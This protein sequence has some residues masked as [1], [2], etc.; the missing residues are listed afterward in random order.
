MA[1]KHIPKI[2]HIAE[3]ALRIYQ[4]FQPERAAMQIKYVLSGQ[5]AR[6][7]NNALAL[8]RSGFF[9]LV[10]VESEADTPNG[11]TIKQENIEPTMP[12]LPFQPIVAR[13]GGLDPIVESAWKSA[14][15]LYESQHMKRK[16]DALPRRMR[17]LLCNLA[18]TPF[19]ELEA[20]NPTLAISRILHQAR[21]QDVPALMR[22]FPSLPSL[23]FENST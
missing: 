1:K 15:T 13:R 20:E 18:G 12:P 10:E 21:T 14:I 23:D 3:T 9:D 5:A 16:N 11:T 4:G 6:D 7:I 17:I 2:T 8:S 22:I 19:S